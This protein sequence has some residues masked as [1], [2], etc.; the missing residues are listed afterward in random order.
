MP[1]LDALF[2]P[3]WDWLQVEVTSRC[4]AACSYCPR[5]L[6]RESWQ[7]RDMDLTLFRRMLP[8]LKRAR[9]VHLQS[10]GEPLLHPEFLTM[11]AET[12]RLGVGV[13]ATSNA[14]LIDR[15]TAR[16]IVRSG[17]SMLALSLAGA[18]PHSNDAVRIGT[19]FA[20]VLEALEHVLVA[21]QEL[22][23]RAPGLHVA[24][25]LL[26]GGI[27]E[28]PRLPG[29]LK[30]LGVDQVV[31]SSLDYVC[32]PGLEAQSLY[33]AGPEAWARARAAI[34]QART[35][36]EQSGLGL[37]ARI[38]GQASVV[39]CAENPAKVLVVGADGGV[40]GCVIDSLPIF[41]RPGFLPGPGRFGS[42]AEQS[43]SDIWKGGDA[44]AF[45]LAH[46]RGTPPEACAAC[47]KLH[48]A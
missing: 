22:G 21:R 4:N 26:A 17:L 40:Y 34:G 33:H 2:G 46:A 11:A 7:D 14:T 18:G 42:A 20:Q 13:G 35:A 37:F 27:G 41:P 12:A 38:A 39:P 1:L 31:V 43:L 23:K 10:W 28:L 44:S 25:M 36:A 19:G 29:L 8:D 30:G 48:C 47:L 16:D 45:R 24:Y 3:R 6:L 15:V 32:A 5:T 9:H